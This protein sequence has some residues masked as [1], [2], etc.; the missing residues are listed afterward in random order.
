MKQPLR[1]FMV[2]G[3]KINFMYE[4]SFRVSSN[5]EIHLHSMVKFHGKMDGLP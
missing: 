1:S 2:Y 5:I 3:I 4:I